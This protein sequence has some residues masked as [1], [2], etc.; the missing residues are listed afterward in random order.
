MELTYYFRLAQRW[1]WLWV[2]TTLIAG[3]TAYWI[4]NQ[5]PAVYQATAK[6]LVGP[7]IVSSLDPQL[8]DFRT[9]AELMHTYAEIA[10][11]QPFLET[12][13][14]DL[15]AEGADISARAI[16]RSLSLKSS[17]ATRIL[18]IYVQDLG[19]NRVVVIANAVARALVRSSPSS[20]IESDALLREQMRTDIEKLQASIAASETRLAQ[21]ET[22]LKST[23]GGEAQRAI[24][25]DISDERN[26]LTDD[27]RT[28]VLLYETLQNT[29]TNQVK[30][31]EPAVTS[32]RVPSQT[33]LKTLL[34]SLAG[35]IV[36]LVIA[37]VA[38]Y[39]LDTLHTA[40]DIAQATGAPILAAFAE[41]R[42]AKPSLNGGRL[43]VQ[44]HPDSPAA[45]NY[46]LLS[47]WL[48]LSPQL[49]APLRSVL[50]TSL[51]ADDHAGE[52]ASNMAITLAHTGKR[53]TLV[54]ANLRHPTI[55]QLF[56]VDYQSGLISALRNSSHLP[57]S[58]TVK[59]APGLSL[60]HGKPDSASP[61]ET[62][63]SSRMVG[64]IERLKRETDILLIVA[65][66]IQAFADSLILA[67]HVDGV[68]AVGSIGATSRKGASNAMQNLRALGTQ[69]IG[70]V[71]IDHRR[72]IWHALHRFR[73]VKPAILP[74][75][76]APALTRHNGN[77]G[78]RL[79]TPPE[80]TAVSSGEP[81][82]VAPQEMAIAPP[83]AAHWIA[84]EAEPAAVV[85]EE[86]LAARP[87]ATPV[88]PVETAVV[89]PMEVVVAP[90][91][92]PVA[93][94]PEETLVAALEATPVTPLEE[95]SAPPVEVVAAPEVV[96]VAV[97]P[98]E[99]PVGALEATPVTP[100]EE[101][102]A[103]SIEASVVTVTTQAEPEEAAPEEPLAPTPAAIVV[104]PEE[105]APVV[106]PEE[107]VVTP[108]ETILVAQSEDLVATLQE[109]SLTAQLEETAVAPQAVTVMAL[110][111]ETA[112]VL[113]EAASGA[114]SEDPIAAPREANLTAPPGET[115]AVLPEREEMAVVTLEASLARSEEPLVAP[116]AA[117]QVAL[118][119][120]TA[121]APQ[122]ASPVAPPKSHA[123]APQK[124]PPVAPPK[125]HG[126]APQKTSPVAPPKSHAVTPRKTKTAA[127]TRRRRRAKAHPGKV[128]H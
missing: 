14:Q 60:L 20:I 73:K 30:I 99:A 64:L 33:P 128:I 43:V 63:A 65:S 12:V 108:Q 68:I 42:P 62:L 112:V 123:V 87:E 47:A 70:I 58:A 8:N 116:Q 71:L 1:L 75:S 88:M 17:D 31:L 124:T 59:W 118:P 57:Q 48:L 91:V 126:V 115:V 18:T 61:F 72:T 96:P 106:P 22:R 56:G 84:P 114:L 38:D 79:I 53:V 98:E 122:K 24:L 26:R 107:E 4:G 109:A 80:T 37:L 35:L 95:A 127:K 102:T 51:Q 15:S 74:V 67:S 100:L 83:S 6:L 52:V 86:V 2:L 85:S 97:A 92:A 119:E 110:P 77:G 45:E 113:Q 101:A 81:V 104:V 90:E 93:V 89:I 39:L 23:P 25:G 54:D 46:H 9:G 21:L 36:G 11:T 29:S 34:G 27:R 55:H 125:G 120:E 103:T 10:T 78:E 76:P 69:V 5:E 41:P 66:P 19:P 44:A 117:P 7:D 49:E 16:G 3:G 121:V 13:S 111:N 82:L 94:A 105:P 40:E 50:L 28:L 32:N